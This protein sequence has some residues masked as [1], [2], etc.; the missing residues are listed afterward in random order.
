V[1]SIR[2]AEKGRGVRARSADP[3]TLVASAKVYVAALKKLRAKRERL[4]AQAAG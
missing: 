1:V 4:H 3:D 2:V